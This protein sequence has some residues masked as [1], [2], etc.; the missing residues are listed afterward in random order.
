MKRISIL[1]ISI[2][3]AIAGT[4]TAQDLDE[5]LARHHEVS[6]I[7]KLQK[8][9]AI[10]ITGKSFQMGMETPFT[11]I[12]MRPD[13]FYLEVPVQ[14]QLMKQAYDGETGWMI[15]PWTGNLDPIELTGEQL[16]GLKMQADMDGMLYNYEEKGYTTELAGTEDFEGSEVFVIKQE[17]EEGDVYKHYLDADSYV[18]IKTVNKMIMQGAEVEFTSFY[19]DYKPVDGILMAHSIEVDMGQQGQRK[20]TIE[21]VEYDPDVDESI[22]EK[23]EPMNATPSEEGQ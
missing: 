4:I 22:F 14:G 16:R 17:S 12:I 11:N 10:K 8:I 21:T 3:I 5:V 19:S 9:D 2:F 20:V 15:A 13:K 6:G 18:L 7:D 1:F 23:P